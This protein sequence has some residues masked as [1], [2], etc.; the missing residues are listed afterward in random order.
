METPTVEPI[1]YTG[2]VFKAASEAR[3]QGRLLVVCVLDEG[4]VLGA[5]HRKQLHDALDNIEVSSLLVAHCICVRLVACTDEENSFARLFPAAQALSICIAHSAGNA[6]VCGPNI[7]QARIA[8]EIQAQLR[9]STQARGAVHMG[10]LEAIEN[11]RLRRLLVSRRRGDMQRVKQA[12]RDF[13][14]DRQGYAYVHGPTKQAA[15]KREG[16]V[17]EGRTGAHLLL[18]VSD[19]RTLTAEFDAMAVF[20]EVRAYVVKELG[21]AGIA[22]MLPPRRVLTDED[23]GRTLA[24]LGLVPTATLLVSVAVA[25]RTQKVSEPW[26]EWPAPHL[27]RQLVYLGIVGALLLACLYPRK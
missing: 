15:P 24:E 12:V 5:A 4:V 9:A 2:G 11:E 27:L 19:G 7:T 22:T 3:K 6:V 1:W 14:D 26:F 23:D 10:S 16:S 20:S 25:V 18:R 17:A 8:A 21:P 13:K